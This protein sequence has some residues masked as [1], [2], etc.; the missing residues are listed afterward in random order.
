M[1]RFD[2]VQNKVGGVGRTYIPFRVMVTEQADAEWP[3][4]H[5]PARVCSGH[6]V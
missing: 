2:V 5:P 4:T 1:F 6:I 3:S